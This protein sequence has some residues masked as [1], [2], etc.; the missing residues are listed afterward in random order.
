MFQP[1]KCCGYGATANAA[2][3]GIGYDC[4]TIPGAEKVSN[5]APLSVS[6][7][8]GKNNGLATAAGNGPKSICC[9]YKD[10]P[11]RFSWELVWDSL[12]NLI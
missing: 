1:S 3:L 9:E 8:C 5:G 10:M 11:F 7:F 6:R 2:I 4:V 12:L